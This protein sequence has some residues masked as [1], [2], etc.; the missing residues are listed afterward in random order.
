M[1]FAKFENVIS[2]IL[3]LVVTAALSIYFVMNLPLP[4]DSWMINCVL[5]LIG[6]CG[7]GYILLAFKKDNSFAIWAGLSGLICVATFLFI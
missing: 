7:F 2:P 3:F 5:T 4:D 1:S 6:V